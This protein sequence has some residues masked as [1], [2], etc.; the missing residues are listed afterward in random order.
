MVASGTTA[1]PGPLRLEIPSIASWAYTHTEVCYVP[2]TAIDQRFSSVFPS[3]R[4][5]MAIPLVAGGKTMGTL[6]IGCTRRDAFGYPVGSFLGTLGTSLSLWLFRETRGAKE[7]GSGDR[8]DRTE[9]IPGFEDLLL[10]ISHQIKSPLTSL[11]GHA[12]LLSSGRLGDLA[13]EQKEALKAMNVALVD[14][15][16]YTDRMLSFMKIELRQETLET[17]WARPSDVVSSLLPVLPEKGSNHGV[18]VSAELPS[19]P[20]TAS[21]DRGRLEQIISNLVSNGI[22]YNRP[23]GQ[24]KIEVRMDGTSH[25]VLEVFNTGEGIPPA[26]LPNVFDRFYVGSYRTGTG[27]L[28]IGLTIVRSFVNQ[29]GGTVNVRSRQGYGSWFTVRLPVS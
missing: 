12:D 25:W 17:A 26:D 23:E 3:S 8:K 18:T 16:D 9:E 5:E 22:Q 15:S 29:M 10:S 19:E 27:G 24:V 13:D 21:F 6:T 2:D 14:L 7:N 11:R 20:F 4:S 28:G 1:E